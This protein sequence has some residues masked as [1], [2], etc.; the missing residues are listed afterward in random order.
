MLGNV[1]TFIDCIVL[2]FFFPLLSLS[3]Q[4]EGATSEEE[5]IHLSEE[6]LPGSGSGS[7]VI[8]VKPGVLSS[9]GT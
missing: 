8:R 9:D 5:A 1:S 7:R 3:S 4:P 2:C 6:G